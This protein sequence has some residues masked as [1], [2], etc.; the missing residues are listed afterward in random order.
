MLSSIFSVLPA[1]AAFRWRSAL[2]V[3]GM[4]IIAVAVHLTGCGAND[5]SSPSL[6]TN[7]TSGTSQSTTRFALTTVNGGPLGGTQMPSFC[8]TVL[9]GTLDFADW[10]SSVDGTVIAKHELRVNEAGIL[11][12]VRQVQWSGQYSKADGRVVVRVGS[13]VVYILFLE[14]DGRRIRTNSAGC[15]VGQPVIVD[16]PTELVYERQ[17]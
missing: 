6:H 16:V 9:N 3:R 15:Y 1:A 13:D 8:P 7:A 5:P 2:A 10:G 12:P 11:G 14:A 17:N 4:S